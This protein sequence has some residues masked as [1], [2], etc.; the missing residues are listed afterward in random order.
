MADN[1]TVPGALDDREFPSRPIVGVGA[2]VIDGDRVL[3]VKR[4]H[5]PLKGEWSLPG[6]AVELGETLQAAIAREVL[7]ETGLHVEVGPIVD[8]FDR[9]RFDGDGRPR[10]HYVLIDF[11]CRPRS[12]AIVCSSD[13]EAAAWVDRSRLADYS[14]AEFTV[15][16]IQKAF[17]QV[18]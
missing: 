15:R 14:V 5:E 10:F 13:A 7:E 11:V 17:E 1:A 8:V 18:G 12:G 9:L 3:L 4:A 16:V 6:G 2:V